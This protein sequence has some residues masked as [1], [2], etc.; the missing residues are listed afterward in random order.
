MQ[1]EG[2][3]K[4]LMAHDS[5]LC[6]WYAFE[7]A[8]DLAKKYNAELYVL[9]VVDTTVV[10]DI[11]HKDLLLKPLKER[12]ERLAKEL[13]EKSKELGVE[14]KYIVKDGKPVDKI[15][16]T[17]EELDVD[18]VVLGSRG[19]GMSGYLLGSVST[20]VVVA[21]KRSVLVARKKEVPAASK[22]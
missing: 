12:A 4:I 11:P 21:C 17:A 3:K 16:E 15:L 1:F 13:E 19:L 9:H 10:P 5:S 8:A 14:V 6:G 2:I 22:L 20:K 7:V 18:L